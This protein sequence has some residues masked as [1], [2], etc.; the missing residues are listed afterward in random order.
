MK[1]IIKAITAPVLMVRGASMKSHCTGKP[2]WTGCG[3]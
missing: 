3:Y 1:K 2:K